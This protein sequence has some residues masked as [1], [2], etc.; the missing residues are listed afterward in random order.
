MVK[1]AGTNDCGPVALANLLAAETNADPAM[2]YTAILRDWGFPVGRS[3]LLQDLWD[4]PSRHL[5]IAEH[6]SG[7]RV[8]TCSAETGPSVILLRLGALKYHWVV[9]ITES[10]WH[11]GHKIRTGPCEDYQPGA[12]V[13]LAYRVG[14]LGRWPWWVWPWHYITCGISSL[15]NLLRL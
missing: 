7:R 14:G 12:R 9:R 11:D 5:L 1:M 15:A 6:Y 13:V 2:L 4:S 3:A 8:G 10:I